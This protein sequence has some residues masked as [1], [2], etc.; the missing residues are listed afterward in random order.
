MLAALPTDE[1]KAA[2]AEAEEEGVDGWAIASFYMVFFS[3][4]MS[5]GLWEGSDRKK[6]V[7]LVHL[8]A[9][10]P[11]PLTQAVPLMEL[12]FDTYWKVVAMLYKGFSRSYMGIR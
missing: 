8:K 2:F 11:P 10:V 7:V 6:D 4:E 3:D 12:G 5:D 1:A 9:N